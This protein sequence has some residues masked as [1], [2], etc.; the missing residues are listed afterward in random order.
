MLIY[1]CTLFK[2]QKPMDDYYAGDL[3]YGVLSEL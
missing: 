2:T 3:R 1:P